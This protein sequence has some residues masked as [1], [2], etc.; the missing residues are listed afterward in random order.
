V[1]VCLSVKRIIPEPMYEDLHEQVCEDFKMMYM[2]TPSFSFQSNEASV[3]EHFCAYIFSIYFVEVE[4]H[5]RKVCFA[6]LCYGLT[7]I[8]LSFVENLRS[9]G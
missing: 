4:L 6:H 9:I 8:V 7:R 3:L 1:I 2:R 5:D